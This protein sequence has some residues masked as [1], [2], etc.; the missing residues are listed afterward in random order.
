MSVV[1]DIIA[2]AVSPI[3]QVLTK[4]QERKQAKEAAVSKLQWAK[5]QGS[6]E[7]VLNEQE[8][9]VVR[10][11]ALQSSWKDEYVT[12]SVVSFLNIIILGSI[13]AAYEHPQVL[14]GVKGAMQV[15]AATGVDI[16][17]L[18]RIVIYAAVGVSVWRKVT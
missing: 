13:A 14:E 2:G 4:R 17:E 1:K 7:V 5:Q 18:L 15:L 16:G 9:E 6:Q 8:I 10:T 11:N 3:T 12:V